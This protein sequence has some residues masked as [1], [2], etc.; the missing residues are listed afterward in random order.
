MNPSPISAPG[1][2]PRLGDLAPGTVAR[3]LEIDPAI[4]RWRERLIAYGLAPGHEV[5]IIQQTPVTVIR[6]ERTELAFESRIA[7]GILVSAGT[8]ERRG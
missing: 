4:S 3:V 6:V 5:E 1:A 2:A 8:A 7:A